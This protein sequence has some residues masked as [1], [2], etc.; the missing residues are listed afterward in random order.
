MRFHKPSPKINVSGF[1]RGVSG[2][3]E[4][5]KNMAKNFL[6]SFSQ[7]KVFKSRT[8]AYFFERKCKD[9]SKQKTKNSFR[10]K[11]KIEN[12]SWQKLFTFPFLP[13]KLKI[14]ILQFWWNSS[15]FQGLRW[16]SRIFGR[17]KKK[18]LRKTLMVFSSIFPCEEIFFEI[19]LKEKF[20]KMFFLEVAR[21]KREVFT[22]KISQI[23]FVTIF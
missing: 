6:E 8:L 2:F 20:T 5:R 21:S 3:F 13:E 12:F 1:L 11:C 18:S 17:G 19:L 22:K 9:L 15:R 14:F 4:M 23:L 10:Q 16:S 7:E